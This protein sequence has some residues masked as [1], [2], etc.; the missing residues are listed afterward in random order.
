MN[1]RGPDNDIIKHVEPINNR[2]LQW[3]TL[4]EKVLCKHIHINHEDNDSIYCGNF[5]LELMKTF[6]I[7]HH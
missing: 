2:I 3:K 1:E 4:T 7:F 6:L 5:I